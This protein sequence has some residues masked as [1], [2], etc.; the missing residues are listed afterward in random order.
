MSEG[1][2]PPGPWAIVGMVAAVILGVVLAG[3]LAGVVIGVLLYGG[4]A[5]VR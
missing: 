2:K 5:G 3:V 1:R 4:W